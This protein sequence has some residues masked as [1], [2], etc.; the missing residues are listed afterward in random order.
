M[1]EEELPSV[2]KDLRKSVYL[3]AASISSNSDNESSFVSSED[4]KSELNP[5][6]TAENFDKPK[7]QNGICPAII[8]HSSTPKS[9]HKKNYELNYDT[10]HTSKLKHFSPIPPINESGDNSFTTQK[11][12]QLCDME[13]HLTVEKVMMERMQ[14]MAENNKLLKDTLEHMRQ[15]SLEEASARR[16]VLEQ[17][18]L[19]DIHEQELKNRP[20]REA[21]LAEDNLKSAQRVLERIQRVKDAEN[22]ARRKSE[23]L[24][25]YQ[26]HRDKILDYQKEYGQCYKD[27]LALINTCVN[28]DILS[29]KSSMMKELKSLSVE[30]E[31]VFKKSR[32]SAIS[33]DDVSCCSKLVDM[34]KQVH[35]GLKKDIETINEE[36]KKKEEVK[37]EVAKK[38]ENISVDTVKKSEPSVSDLSDCF[39]TQS[40]QMYVKLKDY[41]E[42]F[43]K[44]CK[45][46]VDNNMLKKFRFNCQKAV[47]MPVNAISPISG[48][49]LSDKYLKLHNL[50]SGQVVEIGD[51]HV[52]ASEHPDGI[53]YCKKLLAK[54]FVRQGD[55]T[56]SSKPDAA[57]SIAAVLV[58][59][60]VDFPDF[61][62]L[63]MAYFQNSCPYLAPVFMP[64]VEGQSVEDYHKSLG[65]H[66]TDG[67]EVEKQDSFLKRMSGIMRLYAAVL[68]SKVRQPGKRNPLG[69]SEGWRWMSALLNLEPRPDICATLLHDFLEVAGNEMFKAYGAQF[70]KLLAYICQIY[71]PKLEKITPSSSG[72]PLMRLEQFLQKIMKNESIPP[73]EGLLPPNFW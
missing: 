27:I 56:V 21:Q 12:L 17:K 24:Q 30:S 22:E 28:K 62:Q 36:A 35:K 72:G 18:I 57:F 60:W 58:S 14:N 4:S 32:A 5:K 16:L 65:Y 67:G 37:V 51:I 46:L 40:F 49:H 31:N 11:L 44:K 19:D 41:L 64:Q 10:D 15:A 73:P 63:T 66:Y 7:Y 59:L 42:E 1:N 9:K 26:K 50:L 3:K 48:A 6:G 43:E 38:Q 69:V 23:A 70:K 8:I 29:E 53:N 34:I 25:L 39:D 52:S 55:L 61:G 71:F 68:I 20:R 54:K 45:N 2:F 47:T 13:R 33:E